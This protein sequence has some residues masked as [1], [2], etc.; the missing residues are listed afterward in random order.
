[1]D[2]GEL[3]VMTAGISLMPMW[4]ANSS[5]TAEQ[6]LHREMLTLVQAVVQ[7]TTTMWS[8]LGL[9]HAWLTVS[10]MV[11]EPTTVITVKMQECG[12]A[13]YQ[14]SRVVETCLIHQYS[15]SQVVLC[16]MLVLLLT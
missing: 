5:I 3:C 2:P 6:Y 13:L 15:K 14:V 1:M 4:S 7:S 9:R 16:C 10:I 8:A 12:V 11:L